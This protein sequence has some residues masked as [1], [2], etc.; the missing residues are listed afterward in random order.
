ERPHDESDL[1]AVEA[2][3]RATLGAGPFTVERVTVMRQALE[4]SAVLRGRSVSQ[5]TVWTDAIAR[6]LAER[7]AVS[8]TDPEVRLRGRVPATALTPAFD[9]LAN[10]TAPDMAS[11]LELA[12]RQL[13]QLLAT[14]PVTTPGER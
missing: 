10:R 7:H 6:G 11:A 13:E 8:P 4:K 1:R 2:G 14:W 3:L 5:L 12:F 9:E